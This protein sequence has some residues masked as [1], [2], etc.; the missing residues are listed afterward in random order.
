M[1][2]LK[3]I[4]NITYKINAASSLHFSVLNSLNEVLQ[5][6][7]KFYNSRDIIR[8]SVL[9][10]SKEILHR[11]CHQWIKILIRKKMGRSSSLMYH[12]QNDSSQHILSTYTV[13]F[14]TEFMRKMFV[15]FF[16]F[17]NNNKEKNVF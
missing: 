7:R 9:Q 4:C 15:L 2:N 13:L 11:F 16:P 17:R 12:N 5:A 6:M 14:M 8:H 3:I 10:C 1:S